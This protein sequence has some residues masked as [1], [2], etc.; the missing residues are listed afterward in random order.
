MTEPRHQD[1]KKQLKLHALENAALSDINAM[2]E[3]SIMQMQ[4]FF[5]YHQQYARTYLCVYRALVSQ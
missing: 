5:V 3:D 4:V 1:M 2:K